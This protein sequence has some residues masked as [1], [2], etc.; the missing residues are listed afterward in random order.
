MPNQPCIRVVSFLR[1][2]LQAG[3]NLERFG[4]QLRNPANAEQFCIFKVIPGN[5]VQLQ[6]GSDEFW[7]LADCAFGGEM[8]VSGVKFCIAN[9]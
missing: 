4:L 1:A 6:I 2:V 3:M 5:K 7:K 8:T 9:G